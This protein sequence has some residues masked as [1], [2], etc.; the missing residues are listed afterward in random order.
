M[1][2]KKSITNLRKYVDILAALALFVTGIVP[3]VAEAQEQ[4]VGLLQNDEGAFE[5]YTLFMSYQNAYLIDNG[6]LIAHSWN[7]AKALQ[8]L[9]LLANG[10]LLGSRRGCFEVTWDGTTVWDYYYQTQH[11]DIER[12]PNGNTLMITREIISYKDAIDAGRD[13]ALLD[14]NKLWSLH[15]IEVQKT[16]TTTGEI[17][18]EWRAWDHLI[19]DYD[20]GKQNYGIVADHPEL[21][22]LNFTTNQEAD[23]IHTNAIDYNPDLDQII[24]SP[25]HF[26]ELWVI[27]HSTTT[28]EAAGHSGGYSGMGGDIIYRWGNPQ[29]YNRGDPS[30]QQLFFQ[31]DTQW[32]EAGLPGEGHILIFNN[33]RY[34]PGEEYSTIEEI[35]PPVDGYNYSL[36]TPP[37]S[38]YGPAAPLWTYTADPP[39]SFYS[40]FISG[41]QRLHNGNTLIDS[42][43]NGTFFEVTPDSQTVWKYVNP[44]INTGPLTQGDSIPDPPGPGLD[45]QVFRCYRYAPDYPGLAG[46]DLTPT[47]PIELYDDWADLTLQSTT[48]GSVIYRGEGTFS[49]GVGQ[50]VTIKA[51]ASPCYV[52]VNWT[53][54]SG[55]VNIEDPDSPHTTFTMGDQHSTV[56]ANF[57]Y[58]DIDTDGVCDDIDNCPSTP[59]PGQDDDES[60]GIGNVCDNCPEDFNPAQDDGDSDNVGDLC[61]NCISDPNPTQ[62]DFDFDGTGDRCDL[63]DGMIYLWIETETLVEWQEEQGYDDLWNCYKGD[64]DVLRDT[65]VYTQ[66]PGS[67]DLAGRKCW[68]SDLWMSDPGA[69]PTGKVAFFLTSGVSGGIEGSLGQ[70]SEGNERANHN[71]CP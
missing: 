3:S 4:T 48:G 1:I 28:A 51:E 32:I 21:I 69:P 67:N 17:V 19:Q 57:S 68:T 31:H 20:S 9:Y 12:L 34:R 56:Q 45:N 40:S 47:G 53:V 70:N 39:S 38:V 43:Y 33:G 36:E 23:W 14:A 24:V 62:S 50:L 71:P 26:C 29:T 49:Y 59:N 18:W 65:G 58:T 64:L 63:D 7:L 13:P 42:G 10:N 5:G 25:R 22:D 46:R 55:A 61:D 44:L 60:D 2:K 35:V 66:L 15:I 8:P 41:T 54:E 52:F 30:D 6:G 16:G 37:D 27:D 11:H